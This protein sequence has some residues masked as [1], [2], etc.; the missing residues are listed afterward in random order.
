M[1]G[2][3]VRPRPFFVKKVTVSQL[4]CQLVWSPF[5]VVSVRFLVDAVILACLD[6]R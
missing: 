6:W 3:E 2:W 4:V 5:V 1:V